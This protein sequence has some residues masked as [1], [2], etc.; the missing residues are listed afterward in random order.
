MMCLTRFPYK[1]HPDNIALVA[2]MG[3]ELGCSY[4]YCLKAMADYLVPD[5][6]CP[7]NTSGR[8]GAF[9]GDR[10]YQWHVGQ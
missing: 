5:L 3:D 6:G 2:A 7:E 1:E 4:E 8:T 9:Q 10:I